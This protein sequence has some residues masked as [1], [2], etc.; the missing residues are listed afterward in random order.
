MTPFDY[1]LIA[2]DLKP[3]LRYNHTSSKTYNL[4]C[5]AQQFGLVEGIPFP[6]ESFA[7]FDER[8]NLYANELA[9]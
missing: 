3:R 7:K 5:L 2:Y 8:T 9:N 1:G 4:H 6:Y